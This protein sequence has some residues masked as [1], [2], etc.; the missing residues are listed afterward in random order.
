M[1]AGG[2]RYGGQA[3]RYNALLGRLVAG[4]KRRRALKAHAFTCLWVR[5]GKH[6]GV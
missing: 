5:Q 3:S 4:L 1:H 2:G 6:V